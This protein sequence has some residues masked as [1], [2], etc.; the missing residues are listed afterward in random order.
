MMLIGAF[1]GFIGTFVTECNYWN[2]ICY[3]RP[4]GHGSPYGISKCKFTH[5][6]VGCWFSHLALG[7]GLAALYRLT[8][9]VVTVAP[10]FTIPPLRSHF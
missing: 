3:I 6:P 4:D 10:T 9:G 7:V 2:I 8:F 1:A 5:E